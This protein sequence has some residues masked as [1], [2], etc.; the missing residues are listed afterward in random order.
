MKTYDP[1]KPLFSIHIPKCAGSSLSQIL[2]AWF[3]EEFLRH[4]YNEKLNK[5]PK[6]HNLYTGFFIKKLRPG[7]CIHGHFNNNRGNGIRTYYPEVDH[8]CITIIRDPFDHYLSTYF[9]VKREAQNQGGGAFR[10]GKKHPILENGWS[11]EDY[12]REGKKKSY[13]LNFLPSDITP[14]NYQQVLENKFI[15]IGISERLQNSVDIL[16][17]KLGFPSMTVPQTNVSDWNE[18]VPDNAREE[19]EE[20]NPLEVSIYRYVKNNWGNNL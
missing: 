9:Y 2:K 13:I 10:F 14:D 8:Q 17:R 20:N 7:L 12:I 15:Y 16:A 3:K 1:T 11:L 6:K 19:F 4:Y 18:S 5:P